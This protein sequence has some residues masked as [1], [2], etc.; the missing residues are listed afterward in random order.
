VKVFKPGCDIPEPTLRK[1][2]WMI[3]STSPRDRTEKEERYQ[4][5][6]FPA[7]GCTSKPEGRE[8]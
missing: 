2:A 6:H 8:G 1:V 5:A 7:A 4:R 3:K